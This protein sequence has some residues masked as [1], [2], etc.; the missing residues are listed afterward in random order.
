IPIFP[1]GPPNTLVVGERPPSPALD[2]G[3]WFAAYGWDGHGDGDCVMTTND[4]NIANYFADS[5][6]AI[7]GS[8]P[9]DAVPAKKG[10]MVTGKPT[11]FC[12]GSHFL[13]FHPNRGMFLFADVGAPFGPDAA[14]PTL[15]APSTR[16]GGE[17]F[18]MP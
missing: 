11:L 2:F 17:V 7:G 16:S 18:T 12:D 8:P 9:C 1:A 5:T 13:R 14:N 15:P 3:W 6:N 10:G 4:I